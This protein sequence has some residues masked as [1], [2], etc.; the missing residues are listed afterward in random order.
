MADE[1]SGYDRR[2]VAGQ[3]DSQERKGKDRRKLINRFDHYMSI[4]KK[5]PIFNG[6]N[7]N[8]F[9]SILSICKQT[10][11]ARDKYIFQMGEESDSIFVIFKGE[12][13]VVLPD[14]RTFTRIKP[15]GIVGEMGVFTGVKRAAT[16]CA[17]EDSILLIIKK[18]NC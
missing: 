13:N 16:I 8:Q 15:P 18:L 9:H 11:I 2:M 5:T 7:M 4:L 17:K 1:R 6:L 3:N 10:A 12:L 14:G